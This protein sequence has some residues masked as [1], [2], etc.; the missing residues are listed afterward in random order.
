[1][2]TLARYQFL[3]MEIEQL[4][5]Q[6]ERLEALATSPR[7]SNY[8][9]M[10]RGGQVTDGMDI[11][12]KIADLKDLYYFRIGEFLDV[13]AQAEKELEQLGIEER[14]VVRYKYID[15]MRNADIAE[16][17]HYSEATIKRRIKSAREK[18]EGKV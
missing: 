7:I 4:D 2:Q 15:G 1:M 8:S 14:V 11:V 13:Q 9:G 5:E 16:R 18:L 6:I 3:K 10:P 17:I 12:A